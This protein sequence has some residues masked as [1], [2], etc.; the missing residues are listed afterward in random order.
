MDRQID[1]VP[2]WAGVCVAGL[3]VNLGPVVGLAE[4]GLDL[5]AGGRVPAHR[6]HHPAT[7][8]A[9]HRASAEKFDFVLELLQLT[10]TNVTKLIDAVNCQIVKEGNALGHTCRDVCL[11]DPCKLKIDPRQNH[12]DAHLESAYN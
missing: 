8:A 2:G 6:L 9:G 12:Q 7:G 1:H 11:K 10:K 3:K 5:E 4:A